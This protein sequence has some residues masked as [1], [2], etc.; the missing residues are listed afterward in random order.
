M[1]YL[2]PHIILFLIVCIINCKGCKN[3]IK[4]FDEFVKNTLQ[5]KK[6]KLK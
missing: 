4:K 1:T 5:I 2:I 3:V 6:I